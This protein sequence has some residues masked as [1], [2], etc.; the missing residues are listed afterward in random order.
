[1]SE[2]SF[3]SG[4][5]S[6]PLLPQ[7]SSDTAIEYGA[8]PVPFSTIAA[9]HAQANDAAS[10]LAAAAGLQ[11]G[12]AQPLPLDP[13]LRAVVIPG[14]P[15]SNGTGS[16]RTAS[17][18]FPAP[19][20][21]GNAR[22]QPPS[23]LQV[24]SS[25]PSSGGADSTSGYYVETPAG[26]VTTPLHPWAAAGLP[27]EE[28]WSTQARKAIEGVPT[29]YMRFFKLM[30][31]KQRLSNPRTRS[32]KGG[33]ADI[34]PEKKQ[35]KLEW[36]EI[37]RCKAC[38]ADQDSLAGHTENVQKHVR[39]RK[40]KRLEDPPS[41]S[42]L[43]QDQ[44]LT[45][46]NV[47]K[48]PYS[49]PSG[50]DRSP[51][52][53]VPVTPEA[54]G[55]GTRSHDPAKVGGSSLSAVRDF[56]LHI[57]RPIS[58]ANSTEFIRFLTDLKGPVDMLPASDAVLQDMMQK[59]ERRVDALLQNGLEVVK[60]RHDAVS[61]TLS[62]APIK[63]SNAVISSPATHAQVLLWI[64]HAV[65]LQLVGWFSAGTAMLNLSSVNADATLVQLVNRALSGLSSSPEVTVSVRMSSSALARRCMQLMDKS[66]SVKCD[67]VPEPVQVISQAAE[68]LLANLGLATFAKTNH[69]EASLSSPSNSTWASA[70]TCALKEALD[71]DLHRVRRLRSVAAQALMP[72]SIKNAV[73]I[74]HTASEALA[75]LGS[76][77]SNEDDSAAT[78]AVLTDLAKA[79]PGSF[80]WRDWAL[81]LMTVN[82]L[83]SQRKQKPDELG[84]L[85]EFTEVE[86]TELQSLASCL[87]LMVSAVTMAETSIGSLG[88]ELPVVWNTALSL[89][90]TARQETGI[91]PAVEAAAEGLKRDRLLFSQ[92]RAHLLATMLHPSHRLLRV[93]R[94]S[95]DLATRAL[96][97]F[98]DEFGS[99][100]PPEST[101][102]PGSANEGSLSYEDIFPDTSL[103][104]SQSILY[105]DAEIKSLLSRLDVA[106]SAWLT[107][108][109]SS[110]LPSAHD[111]WAQP[112]L[113][114]L[115][116]RAA[117][118]YLWVMP[119]TATR[120][121]DEYYSEVA[122]FSR[123]T[124]SLVADGTLKADEQSLALATLQLRK[125][126]C[127]YDFVDA[128]G[129]SSGVPF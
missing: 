123:E 100:L 60:Q 5:G 42:G 108:A 107:G 44:D 45:V 122:Q 127:K 27:L 3:P 57:H 77:F 118:R 71:E 72:S 97:A 4:T 103:N 39:L 47:L 19:E 94:L 31:R 46:R 1:M 115:L 9:S 13:Q 41:R 121:L 65:N 18:A 36:R 110:V 125:S 82:E 87:R 61:A 120:L 91:T 34:V 11:D 112:G 109:A 101:A 80:T 63:S 59:G 7:S 128:N 95:P 78:L 73:A 20:S 102:A 124:R 119:N 55:S 15:P 69:V 54:S 10:F 24:T 117:A 53:A 37:Y 74:V 68:T 92:S 52:D 12:G 67:F 30:D 113:P 38:G 83:I 8:G 33:V 48:A 21:S 70:S 32:S 116:R 76:R 111:Y 40:C 79:E 96:R 86:I 22:I 62:I 51:S 98:I 43:A 126:A 106:S 66:P 89:E 29:G 104:E 14:H 49:G 16:K 6:V 105:Q 99:E 58:F 26:W 17:Q 23:I 25:A 2:G 84:Q 50:I 114:D 90:G 88:N 81:S 93:F 64:H 75:T 85:P 28:S 56:L 35:V 129:R